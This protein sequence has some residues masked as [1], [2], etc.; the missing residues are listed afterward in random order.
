MNMRRNTPKIS[1]ASV[2][3]QF[4]SKNHFSSLQDHFSLFE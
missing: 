4:D 1:V 3:T 2:S